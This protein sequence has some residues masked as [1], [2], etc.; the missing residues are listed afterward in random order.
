MCETVECGR[1]ACGW[2]SHGASV[3]RARSVNAK[4]LPFPISPS[5]SISTLPSPVNL[6]IDLSPACCLPQCQSSSSSSSASDES[7]WLLPSAC[8]VTPFPFPPR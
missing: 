8:S 7:S 4:A 2:R 5:I 6:P 1:L 3:S